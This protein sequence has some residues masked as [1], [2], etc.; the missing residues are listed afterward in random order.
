[1]TQN[2]TISMTKKKMLDDLEIS[3]L[4]LD[5]QLDQ[6]E[7]DIVELDDL[8]WDDLDPIL[9]RLKKSITDPTYDEMKSYLKDNRPNSHIFDTGNI[10]ASTK[11][12]KGQVI[13][14]S[15]VMTSIDKANGTLSERNDRLSKFI[16]DCMTRL[17]KTPADIK[18]EEK[19]GKS[20]LAQSFKRDGLA[21]RI[22]YEKGVLVKSGLRP[23]R[24]NNAENCT[25]NIKYV[26]G[27]PLKLSLP[28]TLQINGEIECNLATFNKIVEDFKNGKNPAEL[29]SLPKNPRNYASGSI[30][31][32]KDPTITKKRQLQFTA[33]SITGFHNPPFT[34]AIER[35]K[36]VNTVLG[37]GLNFVRTEP[38]KYE[39][40]KKME[41]M[42]PDLD[43]EVDGIV[44]SVN[45]LE[46]L[47]ALGNAADDPFNNP[48]GL[49]AWK[50]TEK[51]AI[52]KIKNIRVQAGRTGKHTP[53]AEFDGVQLAGTTVTNCTL[54]NFG[55]I[56]KH[57]LGVGA[58]IEVIKSG[59]II[60]W[61]QRVVK[62]ASKV[63]IIDKCISCGSPLTKRQ[64]DNTFEMF[65][66]NVKCPAKNIMTL[67]HYLDEYGVKG[68][69]ESTMTA[70]AESGA[71]KT[72]A[73]FYKLTEKD[74]SR[75]GLSERESILVLC[76]IHM[77]EDADQNKD[78][79][80]LR[81][82]L[83][84]AY[85][86]QKEIPAAQLFGCLGVPG[87]S[88]NTGT[89]LI[90]YFRE[91]GKIRTASQEDLEKANNVGGITAKNI[92]EYFRDNKN[93]VDDLL[94]FV[95]PVDPKT[96]KLTGK[97]FC[98]SGGFDLGKE[99]WER[100]VEDLGG[101]CKGSVSKKINYLV[102][103]P[104]SGSKSEKADE[105]GIP[106]ITIDD[107]QKML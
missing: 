64:G 87:A 105:L 94:K 76:A 20:F 29:D 74:C 44:I 49:L 91:F 81:K 32:F 77:I 71:V 51:S 69:G 83:D 88:K 26:A 47:D 45:N 5:K 68:I 84:K 75:S 23:H 39:D 27:V 95:K 11:A 10:T 16:Q 58:E 57:G 93:D 14:H 67:L 3:K 92:F 59:K 24:G 86:T 37:S 80:D 46:D 100:K 48:R 34:T 66:E 31:Q 1:M 107:L 6:L 56:E 89:S 103:G 12:P 98:F 62:K 60:P 50:F 41:E 79:S 38:F 43:Y 96:G 65:C 70:L 30:R 61:C 40:L 15:P 13:Q 97:V 19:A 28:L 4:S 8:Y 9:P 99:H 63:F 82:Q 54:H 2:P 35:A 90:S 42:V 85:K 18:A 106:R 53:I 73:D 36:W 78:N 17:G 72:M 101:E 102:F 104:G 33:H 22:Y 21:C 7:Y 55:Y 52:V 25:S